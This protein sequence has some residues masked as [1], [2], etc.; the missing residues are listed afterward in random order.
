MGRRGRRARRG[1]AHLPSAARQPPPPPSLLL[2]LPVSLLYTHSLRQPARGRGGATAGSH[3]VSCEGTLP[4]PRRSLPLAEG[5]NRSCGEPFG[6]GRTNQLESCACARI[7][8]CKTPSSARPRAELG[9]RRVADGG[10]TG[11]HGG[12]SPRHRHLAGAPRPAPR[13]APRAP[14]HLSASTSPTPEA[15]SF[16]LRGMLERVPNEWISSIGHGAG[17][18]AVAPSPAPAH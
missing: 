10:G 17:S 3:D 5:G 4:R 14:P 11:G 6:H 15:E 1:A 2:P 13:A 7:A 18:H 12:Q 16:S 9:A 8:P